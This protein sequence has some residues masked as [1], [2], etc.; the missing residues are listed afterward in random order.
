MPPRS[1]GARST[2]RRCGTGCSSRGSS[3]ITVRRVSPPSPPY[4]GGESLEW[5]YG[6]GKCIAGLPGRHGGRLWPAQD[7]PQG[8][9][10]HRP[11][12]TPPTY[13]SAPTCGNCL[14]VCPKKVDMLA[15]MPAVREARPLALQGA[16]RA[17][18]RLRE[19]IPVRQCPWPEPAAPGAVGRERRGAGA[20]PEQGT[21]S[22]RRALLC[23][24]L[25]ELPPPGPGRRPRFARVA[26]ALGIDW[27]ILGP[28]GEDAR[29]LAAAGRREGPVRRPGRGRHRR[30]LAKYEF[31]RI[32]TPGPACLQRPCQRVP[33]ARARASKPCTTPSSLPRSSIRSLGQ[34]AGPDGDLSRP[35]LPGPPER[36]VRRAPALLE[37]I[38]GVQLVEMGRCRENAYCCGG[39][40]GGMWLDGFTRDHTDRAALRAPGPRSCPDRCRRAGGLL[41]LRGVPGS[42]MRPSRPVTRTSASATSSS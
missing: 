8:P 23:R 29:R 4:P 39:G 13:G 21:G 19:D 40:G 7:P 25:L 24:G 37:A 30:T 18:G 34:G 31:S 10:R 5:C 12:A 14:R 22:G 41:S 27:A 33:P 36:G 11:V 15:I 9:D 6:C 2:C 26:A 3:P 1:R 35:V 42:A 28:E 38:P 17:A 20:G 32:V 16:G